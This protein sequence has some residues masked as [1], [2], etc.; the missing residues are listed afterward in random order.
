MF[1]G[2]FKT[3]NLQINTIIMANNLQI[4]NIVCKLHHS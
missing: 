3:N 1:F 2:A 4:K